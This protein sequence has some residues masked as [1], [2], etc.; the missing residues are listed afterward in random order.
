MS[1]LINETR[2]AEESL[3]PI[4][5]VEDAVAA[6]Q[7][8]E[9]V[10]SK[11]VPKAELWGQGVKPD[12][13]NKE[14]VILEPLFKQFID[15]KKR[16]SWKEKQW[17]KN[18]ADHRNAFDMLGAVTVDD[19]T[20]ANVRIFKNKL[21]DIYNG[22]SPKHIY[23]RMQSF[24]SWLVSSTDYLPVNV[25]EQVK[26]PSGTVVN[27][28]TPI[29]EKQWSLI[30]EAYPSVP[31][32]FFFYYTG[33]NSSEVARID[34]ASWLTLDGIKCFQILDGK[35]EMRERVVP[36][37]KNIEHLYGTEL[38]AGLRLNREDYK[39][40]DQAFNQV[41]NKKYLQEFDLSTHG[42]RHGMIQRL[43]NKGIDEAIRLRLVGHA[44]ANTSDKVY[45]GDWDIGLLKQTIDKV[46]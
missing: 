4:L 5:T 20:K 16:S 44:A 41:I 24:G 34:K 29:V 46:A 45:G 8:E 17:K 13:V 6:K 7:Y 23:G 39:D 36:L 19:L 27:H 2:E 9:E 30:N 11:A 33:C 1:L 3:H 12:A 22:T 43:R 18:E 28:K 42:F 38:W 37:H 31:A 40:I 10:L 15:D 25:F 26:K 32:L 35:N 14:Q 21:I